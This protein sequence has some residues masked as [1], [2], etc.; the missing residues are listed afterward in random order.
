MLVA[1]SAVAADALSA[2]KEG[3]A[4]ANI[5]ANT[6]TKAVGLNI[7]DAFASCVPTLDREDQRYLRREQCAPRGAPIEVR[8]VAGMGA[9]SR[10]SA[11]NRA[12]KG[13]TSPR[14]Q[15]PSPTVRREQWFTYQSTMVYAKHG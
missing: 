9:F 6:E 14:R 5:A 4:T 1:R 11:G 10:R 15:R 8:R 2:A 3:A 7:T 12:E 13:L